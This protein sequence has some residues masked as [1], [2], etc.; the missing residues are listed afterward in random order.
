MSQSGSTTPREGKGENMNATAKAG[1]KALI[2]DYCG[3]VKPSMSFWIGCPPPGSVDWAMWEGTGKV[4][5][6]GLDCAEKGKADADAA[7]QRMGAPMQAAPL[8]DKAP[9]EVRRSDYG[10]ANCLWASCECKSGSKYKAT[11]RLVEGK[12]PT[13]GGY[14]YYD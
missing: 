10:C 5:C 11:D 14:T 9:P 6:D 13:C 7:I 3:K 12:H 1:S 8:E 2:C 4:S